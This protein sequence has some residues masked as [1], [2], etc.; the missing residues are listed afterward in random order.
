[1]KGPM[2]SGATQKKK[3][4]RGQEDCELRRSFFSKRV[5]DK[6]NKLTEEEASAPSTS[7]KRRYDEADKLR[8]QRIRASEFVP[9]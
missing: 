3:I 2:A 1:M 4:S 5:I 8:Q 9:R 6:W 7:D